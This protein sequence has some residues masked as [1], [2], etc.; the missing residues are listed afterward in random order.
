MGGLLDLGPN[1]ALSG[2]LGKGQDWGSGFC[3][4]LPGGQAVERASFSL[5]VGVGV[6][7]CFLEAELKTSLDQ[8]SVKS[9]AR[10]KIE[11]W[12]WDA[13]YTKLAP[14]ND[15]SLQS[16]SWGEMDQHLST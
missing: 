8:G 3:V 4:H 6:E 1:L 12:V 5:S 2:V 10:T 16:R 11:A 14:S 13:P 7:R 15:L 9:K